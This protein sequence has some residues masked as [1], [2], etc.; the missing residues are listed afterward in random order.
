LYYSDVSSLICFRETFE[1]KT[2]NLFC[3]LNKVHK[4]TPHYAIGMLRCLGQFL[5]LDFPRNSLKR[6]ILMEV[7]HLE[8]DPREDG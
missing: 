6:K 3:S 4:R 1:T 7:V 8:D 2:L 5:S